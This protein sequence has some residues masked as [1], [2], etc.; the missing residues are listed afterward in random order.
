MDG[1]D[2]AKKLFASQLTIGGVDAQV[3]ILWWLGLV[4]LATWILLRT[5]S[6]TGSSRS[7]AT[8]RRPARSACR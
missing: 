6:A 2:S 3:T 4:A 5:R 7:A 1:F 8:R